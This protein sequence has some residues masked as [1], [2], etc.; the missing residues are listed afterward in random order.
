[1]KTVWYY[2]P[3]DETPK[4][5]KAMLDFL[6]AWMLENE[7]RLASHRVEVPKSWRKATLPNHYFPRACFTRAIQFIRNSPHLP[8]A[9]YVFGDAACGG[10]QQ[11][12]WVEIGE[13]VFDGVQQEFYS[14]AGFYQSERARPWY[15]FTRQA[16]L[17]IDRL[18]KRC[19]SSDYRWDAVLGLPWA[20]YD[21]PELIDVDKAKAYWEKKMAGKTRGDQLAP[22][23]ATD[24]AADGRDL[25][26]PRR[27]LQGGQP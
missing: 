27:S 14:K 11:H 6:L 24:V 26:G 13:V 8:D 22:P 19:A 17:R 10:T 9:L 23:R 21:N 20:D 1:M 4:P 7:A 5:K 15:R 18:S 3:D 25:F 12:G 2:E 16:T